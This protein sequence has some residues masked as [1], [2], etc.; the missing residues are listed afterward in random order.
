MLG[1]GMQTVL[2]ELQNLMYKDFRTTT[3]QM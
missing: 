3:S 2:H 1:L